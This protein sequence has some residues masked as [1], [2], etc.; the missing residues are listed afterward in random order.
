MGT[1]SLE[2]GS[3]I[4]AVFFGVLILAGLVVLRRRQTSPFHLLRSNVWLAV[5]LAYCFLAITWSDFPFVAFKRWIKILGHPIMASIILT[6]S[7]PQE[8][9]R[10]TLKRT[11]YML[12]PPSILVI[13][14]YP[15]VGRGFDAWT[16]A[17]VNN[18]ISNNKNELGYV[19]LL[20][21]LSFF[22]NLLTARRL[23]GTVRK[24][25][26]EMVV[27]IGFL[28]MIWWLFAMAH[29]ATSL[30]CLLVGAATMVVLGTPLV[31]KRFIGTYLL[32][33]ALLFGG[34]EVSFGVYARVVE[35]FGRDPTLTDRTQVWQ[36]VLEMDN[37]PIL[38][39]GFESFWL[40]PR[41]EKLWAKWWWHPNEAHNG[42]LETYLNLGWV[43]VLILAGV[44]VAS[45]RKSRRELLRN[46]DFGRFRLALLL[47]IVAYNYTEAT[48]KAVHLL[49]TMFYIIALDYPR[50]GAIAAQG[51][52]ERPRD[53]T[54]RGAAVSFGAV[55]RLP[56][57]F[58]AQAHAA[59][60]GAT[61]ERKGRLWVR[62]PR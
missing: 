45:F 58:H 29:S 41:L 49:W 37:S 17:A 38:G 1:V 10:R 26:Y 47:A 12:I 48:F 61:A 13:K 23:K 3:P 33:A 2:D 59:V 42:Y 6:E 14:Y 20:F 31:S 36:D 43:G 53:Q 24:R 5:F 4:D 9:V 11:G 35:L 8:A 56:T 30:A 57:A 50:T 22:W 34:A 54:E 21:G 60:T 44:L 51:E 32:V 16:G 18:G 25:L 28:S 27:S 19:C 7:D 46:L 62:T 52:L 40:G 15:Q 39:F 55:R